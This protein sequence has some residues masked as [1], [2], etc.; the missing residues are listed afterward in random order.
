M[1]PKQKNKQK[2]PTKEIQQKTSHRIIAVTKWET[3]HP[4]GP[5]IGGLRHLIFHSHENGFDS[6]LIRIGR[7]LYLDE[8][9]FYRWAKKHRASAGGTI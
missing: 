7:R 6:V 4:E 2:K 5:P 9:A 8:D 3:A 1:K